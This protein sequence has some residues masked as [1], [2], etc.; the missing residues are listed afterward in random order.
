[1]DKMATRRD[2]L[3]QGLVAAGLGIAGV[4]AW[5][6]PA[7]AQG[8]VEVPFT[9]IP[10]NTRWDIPPERRLLD[11]RTIDGVL[12]PSDKFATTQHYNHPQLDPAAFRLEVTGLVDRPQSL[13]LDDLK[14]LGAT[15]LVAAFECSGNRGPLHGL[16]GSGRWTGVPLARLLSAVGLK[17]PVREVVFYGADHG[18]EEVDF[19]TQKL[20]LDVRFGRSLPRDVALSAEPLLAWALNGDP[21]SRHQGSPLRLIVPGWYGVANV[22][23]LTQIHAQEE[24]FMGKYQSRWYRTI[25][26]TTLNGETTYMETA[27]TR[28][29]LNSFVARVTKLGNRCTVRGVV[30]NDGTPIKQVEVRVDDGPWGT[31]TLDSRTTDRFG[32]KLFSYVWNNPAPG[33]HTVVSRAT[34]ATGRVQP[35]SEDNAGK[36]TFLEENSQAPRKVVVS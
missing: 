15:D 21:L 28:M 10:E 6:L 36:R 4:P 2:V 30:L 33:P 35:T 22:K 34:D 14:K 29:Q 13:A 24:P 1:M 17:T 5:V 3:K 26:Q 9:D 25:R 7:L 19:R 8:E 31:A 18:E 20:M 23:W 12:T 11:I 27:V 16:C 32:W